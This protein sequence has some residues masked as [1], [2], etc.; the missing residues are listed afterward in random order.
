MDPM[1]L[2]FVQNECPNGQ[3]RSRIY[4]ILGMI[5]RNNEKKNSKWN[6]KCQVPEAKYEEFQNR[7]RTLV[8][9]K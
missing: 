9:E 3:N 5:K 7:W 6:D 4:S 2:K 8:V 1:R